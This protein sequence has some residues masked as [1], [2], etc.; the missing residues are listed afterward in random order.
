MPGTTIE[1][2]RVFSVGPGV[3]D[4][5]VCLYN[6]RA[7]C[8]RRSYGLT[9]RGALR[10]MDKWS[11]SGLW[12]VCDT[13]GCSAPG[14]YVRCPRGAEL[15]SPSRCPSVV[16]RGLSRHVHTAPCVAPRVSE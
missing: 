14:H 12:R 4:W 6:E 9:E 13:C 3:R 10:V 11:R 7:Q 15:V 16:C 1:T 8:V 2:G 5:T